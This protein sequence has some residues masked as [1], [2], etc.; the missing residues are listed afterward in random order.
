[1]RSGSRAGSQQGFTYVA[2]LVA[3]ATI[4]A[5]AAA[6]GELWSQAERRERER[7]L[8][9]IGKEFRE[10]VRRYYEAT[11]GPAKSYPQHLEDLLRDQSFPKPRSHLRKMYRDPTTG[12]AQWAV[13]ESPQGGIMGVHSLSQAQPLKT[14]GFYGEDMALEGATRYSEWLFTYNASLPSSPTGSLPR[15]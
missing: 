7:E 14:G 4:G 8:L 9:F 5:G 6:L 12:K 13:V 15:R 1:M 3:V 10:A 11:P 2:L